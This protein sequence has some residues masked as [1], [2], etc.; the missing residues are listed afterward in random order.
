MYKGNS[1]NYYNILYYSIAYT[2][3]EMEAFSL[4]LSALHII[5]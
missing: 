1:N 4:R 3:V 2:D 5:P